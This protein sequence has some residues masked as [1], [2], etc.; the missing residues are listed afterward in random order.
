MSEWNE[1]V[2][3]GVRRRQAIFIKFINLKY[4]HEYLS[5]KFNTVTYEVTLKK[6]S[7]N[8]FFSNRTLNFK[9]LNSLLQIGRRIVIGIHITAINISKDEPWRTAAT[10]P[11]IKLFIQ[12]IGTSRHSLPVV[13]IPPWYNNVFLSIQCTRYFQYERCKEFLPYSPDYTIGI[14]A[15]AMAED[16]L[17]FL[18]EFSP[19]YNISVII[20]IK[21]LFVLGYLAVWIF[22]DTLVGQKI[23]QTVNQFLP[24]RPWIQFIL[25]YIIVGVINNLRD[26]ILPAFSFSPVRFSLFFSTSLLEDYFQK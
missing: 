1:I 18:D 3:Y 24:F 17:S 11:Y 9:E 19:P 13:T 21:L 8:R 12:P 25:L 10:D 14:D 20:N 5:E 15:S 7:N 16:I 2:F 23:I 6:D 4:L 26:Y 22:N